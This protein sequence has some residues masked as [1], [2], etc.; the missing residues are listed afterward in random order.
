MASKQVD[1]DVYNDD[2]SRLDIKGMKTDIEII[3]GRLKSKRSDLVTIPSKFRTG[4][5]RT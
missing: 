1:I 2:G 4:C 3:L 5:P